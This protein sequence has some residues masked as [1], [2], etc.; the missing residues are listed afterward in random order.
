M[1]RIRTIWL[2][3]FVFLVPVV[4]IAIWHSLLYTDIYDPKNMRYVCWKNNLCSIDQDRALS[5]MSH[6][7]DAPTMVVGKS[8][9]ALVQR[10]GFLTPLNEARPYLQWCYNG[11]SYRGQDVEFLRKSD[12]MVIFGHGIAT[13]LV[14]VKGC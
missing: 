12:W 14:I 8:K 10:F 9:A 13:T 1:A 5:V 3:A 2:W 4:T 11:S 6:D 7:K